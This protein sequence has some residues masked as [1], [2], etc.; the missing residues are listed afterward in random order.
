LRWLCAKLIDV[1][2][3][4]NANAT[5]NFFAVMG[6]FLKSAASAAP[7]LQYNPAAQTWFHVSPLVAIR[8]RVVRR[9][10]TD[11]VCCNT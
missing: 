5:K 9:T 4:S 8:N 2:L 7:N 10:N 3:K 11:H 1:A 6:H